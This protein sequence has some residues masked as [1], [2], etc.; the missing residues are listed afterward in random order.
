MCDEKNRVLFTDIESVVLS[1]DFKLFNES[2]VLLRVPRKKNMYSVDLKNVAPSGDPLGKFDGKA[3]EGFFVGYSVNSKEFRVFNNRTRIVEETLHITF[4]ENK[5][6]IAGNKPTWLFNIDTLTKFMNYK[7]IVAGNQ[8][9][10][11]AGKARVETVPDKDYILLPLWTQDP[12]F[13]SSSKDSPS[14]GY[15]PLG[16]DEKK[17][18]K[19]PRNI[20]S[21]VSNTEEP[22]INQEKEVNVNITNNINAVSPTINVVGINDI[23]VDKDIVYGCADDLNMPN[24]EEI[25]Y[26]D[27]DEDVGVE[28][29]M[30]NLDTNI[31]ISPIL[32]T[33]IHKDHPVEQ[34]IRDIH[35]AP[36]T[37]RMTKNVTNH[38]PKKQVWTLVDLPNG[39]RPIGTKWIYKNK[40]DKR[41]IV[42]RN[43][44]RLV[45]QCYTQEEG[46]DYD[47]VFAPV[48]RIEAIRI[49]EKV[50]VCQ[51]LGFKD[52]EFPDIVY[53]VEKALYG[54]HQASRVCE[55]TICIVKNLM[56]H[57][58][59]KH[60][61]IQHHFI[62][63]SNKKKV[64]QMIKIHTDHNVADLFTKAF[65]KPT[66]SEGFEQIVDF[67]NAN[68]IKYELTV[69]LTIYTSCIKQFWAAA[70]VNTINGEEQIQALVDKKKMIIT[71]TSVRSDLQLKDDKDE[72]VYKEMYDSVERAATTSIGLDAE[73]D[74]GIIS[75]T[76]FTA[77]LNEPSSIG[78]SSCS[79]PRRQ[80]TIGD[81]AAQ[82][83]S[84]RVSKFSSD[85]PLSRVNILRSGEDRLTLSELIKLCTQL[86]SRVLALETTKTNQAL[87]IRSLKQRVKKLEKK[88]RRII[89]NLDA[90]E[91]VTFVDEAQ[92]RN[93]QVMFDTSVLDDKEV[94][95]K[96]EV[97]TADLVTTA[98]EVVTT[99]GVKVSATA[100]T[101]TNSIDDITLAK[102]LVALKGAKPMVKEPKL[103]NERKNH[104]GRLRAEEKRRKP[105]TKAQKRNQM[106]TYLKNM[107][108]FTH[109]QLKNK[110]FEEVH[111][112]FD[113][114][115][116]WINSFVPMDKE[117]TEG[118]S[119]R[120][121]EE[122]EFDKSKKKKLDEKVEV[123]EDND[124]EEAEM[125]MYIKIIFDDEITLD[126]IPL[127]TKPSIIVDWKIIKEGKISS[128]QIIR[129]DGSSKRPEEA[130]ERVLWGDLKVMF[131]PDIESEVWRKIQGNKV[132]VWK[133]LSS[134]GVYFVRFQNLD[135][136]MLVEK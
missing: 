76:Q 115:M 38:E 64:I 29:D 50:Y 96:K 31:P 78:T 123:K 68:P 102:A 108:G 75:K 91:G 135:I 107:A 98:G 112:A 1:P 87:K 100:T 7:P 48:A 89:D 18:V 99:V 81:A 124:Q 129:H 103:M 114:T 93:D 23:A 71:E 59:T 20:D 110:S 92:G 30:T 57:S 62:R 118:S 119:K 77:T 106:C 27:D 45:A 120:A 90:D 128:Y 8:S 101:L 109:N 105:P 24:L 10:G 34:I 84:E 41:C 117:V 17:D 121:G 19:G 66:E 111:K 127:A 126:A 132:T 61:K 44:A 69:N 21:E 49:E 12:L 134:C 6:D 67:L 28:A 79:G 22:I 47:E 35:S 4:L 42:V 13:S 25:V 51:P 40:K 52:L 11:S 97:S 70:K 130:Y 39:K 43:K 73:Q 37:R 83:R 72:A 65:N 104:F 9:N 58:K 26:S 54:L 85:P 36:Q 63:D 125:K 32:T 5:L 133:L 86:Q 122:L 74:R 136:F 53:K 131:E 94:V 88:A 60:I 2:Q 46:I 15:K 95:A 82:T 16:D 33:K 55:S 80:E 116:S 56:F 14:V 3:D 113:N